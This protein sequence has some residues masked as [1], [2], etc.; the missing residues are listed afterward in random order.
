MIRSQRTPALK[1][2]TRSVSKTMFEK[3]WAN[4]IRYYTSKVR[5]RGLT[6]NQGFETHLR[7][8]RL[9]SRDF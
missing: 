2:A 3:C 4:I 5:L 1:Q 6:E 9:C 7:G 8:F